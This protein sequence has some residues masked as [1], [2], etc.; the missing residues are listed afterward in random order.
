MGESRKLLPRGG[1]WKADFL[2]LAVAVVWGSGFAAGRVAAGHLNPLIYN[3]TRFMLGALVL[4]PLVGKRMK[5]LR[6]TEIKVGALGGLLLLV[7]AN[8]QQIGLRFTTAG[9]AGFITGLY[10][11]LVP[12]L[13]A[14]MWKTSPG[15]ASGLASVLATAGL[16]LL[17]DLRNLS[18]SSGDVWE[19]VGALFWALHVILLDRF[20]SRVEV[21]WLAIVQYAVCG[22]LST[23]L[24]LFFLTPEPLE[25]WSA[26][27]WAVGYNGVLSVGLGFTLQAV[28]QRHAPATD[29]AVLLSMES[30]FAATFGW[31]LLGERLTAQQ[32]AGCALMLAGMLLAQLHTTTR[33]SG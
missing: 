15:W 7:A 14:A 17:S 31:I 4:V 24:G 21:L 30:V 8:V 10:V 26:A 1:R 6:G 32:L 33:H 19:L 16:F 25:G 22:V 23:L 12:L 11:V 29:A 18:L 28:G 9:Q 3:G 27:W 20:V 5:R 13:L 2:L